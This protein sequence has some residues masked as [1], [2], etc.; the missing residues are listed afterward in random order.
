MISIN[1]TIFNKGFLIE[2]VL[3]AIKKN[4]VLDYEIVIVL[5]GCTDNSEEIVINFFKSNNIKHKIFYAD[6][7]FETK[8]NNIAAKNS[9]NDIIIIIQ[10]DMIINELGWDERLIKPLKKFDD[11]VSVSANCAHDFIYNPN[12]ISEKLNYVP[13][14]HCDIL[15]DVNH[16]RKYNI[17]RDIFSIRSTSNRGPLAINHVDMEK[18]NYF[19][20]CF[21]PQMDDDHDFHYR[22]YEKMGKI[23]GLYWI[24]FISELRWGSTRLP[25][26][27]SWIVP[28]SHKNQ[29]LL[30]NRH[31]EQIINTRPPEERKIN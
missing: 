6:N 21:S 22:A 13:S 11:V 14:F 15:K 28:T 27:N 30:W 12:N 9:D 26:A 17:E 2:R 25:N 29:R 10:D 20:E 3:N 5:D 16:V 24:D 7:V 4:S 1:L 19:D 23:T 8:A 18:L 31:R